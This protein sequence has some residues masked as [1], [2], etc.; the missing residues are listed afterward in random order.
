MP[1]G[2]RIP[3]I[4]KVAS[5]SKVEYGHRHDSQFEND[6]L[7]G[8]PLTVADHDS[9]TR[10][11]KM[12]SDCKQNIE[13]VVYSL[14]LALVFKYLKGDESD[15][16][17]QLANENVVHEEEVFQGLFEVDESA[18]GHDPYQDLETG[19]CNS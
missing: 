19:H 18:D 13:N 5:E 9:E 8:T 17:A 14:G 3:L 10:W 15:N 4:E 12:M 16:G 6:S 11:L 2:K 7:S 1:V